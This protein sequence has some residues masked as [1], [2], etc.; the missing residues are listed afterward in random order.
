MQIVVRETGF[1]AFPMPDAYVR[2]FAMRVDVMLENV[3]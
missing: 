1:S 3:D 2:P